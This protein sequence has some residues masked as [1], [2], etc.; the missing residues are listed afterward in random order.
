M[1][2]VEETTDY[3]LSSWFRGATD[4]V[5]FSSVLRSLINGIGG[6][7]VPGVAVTFAARFGEHEQLRSVVRPGCVVLYGDGD[8]AVDIPDFLSFVRMISNQEFYQK[9]ESYLNV[10]GRW[11]SRTE[12][13]EVAGLM[14]QLRHSLELDTDPAPVPPCGPEDDFFLEVEETGPD[15][16]ASMIL[17][18][19]VRGVDE[20]VCSPV[21]VTFWNDLFHD[22]PD[23]AVFRPAFFTMTNECPQT[24]SVAGRDSLRVRNMGFCDRYEDY[25]E[26]YYYPKHPDQRAEVAELMLG[27]RNRLK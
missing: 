1:Q 6:T 24:V 5:S 26:R 9:F 4:D 15:P 12:R 2:T 19:L 16:D 14:E 25:L 22:D 8:M 21:G 17:A 20:G 10:R 13:T 11:W 23:W 27:L 18:H 7:F 3:I